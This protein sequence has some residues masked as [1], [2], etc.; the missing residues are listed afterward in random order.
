MPGVLDNVLDIVTS[1][2]IAGAVRR[3]ADDPRYESLLLDIEE[4]LRRY[5]P[6]EQ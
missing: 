5:L 2:P 6:A 1:E 3:P 4:R